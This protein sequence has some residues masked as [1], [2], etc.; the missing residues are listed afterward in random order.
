VRRFFE[1]FGAIPDSEWNAFRERLQLRRYAPGDFF[2]RPNEL[3]L[4]LGLVV[5]GLFRVFYRDGGGKEF[6]R[7][8][9]HESRPIGDYAGYLE[10][11]VSNVN[12]VALEASQVAVITFDEYFSMF[13]RHP[14]WDRVGRKIVEVFYVTRE[15]READFVMLDARQRYD[16][17]VKTNPEMAARVSNVHLA[18][19]LG[20]KPETLSR[21]KRA[22]KGR[23]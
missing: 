22:R 5:S 17:F 14:C 8:L 21:L 20:M 11:A 3:P 16:N 15:R 7:A 12:I 13:D 9:A 19:Y 10:R 2:Q 6:A 4:N 18:S 23:S 1:A